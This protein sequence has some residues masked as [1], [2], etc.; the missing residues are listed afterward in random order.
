MMAMKGLT[1][2]KSRMIVASIGLLVGLVARGAINAIGKA[3]EASRQ[4]HCVQNLKQIGLGLH[5]YHA[6]FDSFP[7]AAQLNDRLPVDKR[8]SWQLDVLPYLF[9]PHCWGLDDFGKIDHSGPWDVGAQAQ[10]AVLPLDPLLCP[11]F[12]HQPPEGTHSGDHYIDRSRLSVPVA[13]AYVGITGV[14]T[15]AASYPKSDLR[16]GIF[17]DARV[18]RYEDVTDGMA[19]TMMVAETS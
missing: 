7:F 4:A 18:T 10:F 11:A 13:T 16:A 8:Q 9:C 6:S 5:N 15:D 1:R 19:T 17:G 12:P 14:G 2:R 3:N